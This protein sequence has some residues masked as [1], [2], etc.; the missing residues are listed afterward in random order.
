MNCSELRMVFL[1]TRQRVKDKIARD[2]EERAQKVTSCY[3]LVFLLNWHIFNIHCFVYLLSL[4]V[5]ELRA[6]PQHPNQ[7]NPTSHRPPVKAP[8]LLRRNMMNREY[9]YRR[10][11]HQVQY[12]T[13]QQHKARLKDEH[14]LS[15]YLKYL[16]SHVHVYLVM[17][18]WLK[19]AHTCM[20]SSVRI[21]YDQWRALIFILINWVVT[22]TIT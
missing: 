4:V 5:G 2:R 20:F 6:R 15:F 7:P 11:L 19:I 16:L 21:I 10:H 1:L 17:F 9:R 18:T 22:E 3:D 14:Y 12:A 8:H 13:I